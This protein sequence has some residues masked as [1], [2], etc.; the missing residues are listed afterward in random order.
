[1]LWIACTKPIA[2]EDLDEKQVEELLYL[3][4]VKD[5]LDRAGMKK[6]QK[7]QKLHALYVST[8]AGLMTGRDGG[9]KKYVNMSCRDNNRQDASLH[10]IRGLIFRNYLTRSAH[11]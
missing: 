8:T 2:T 10:P 6:R 7:Q 3:L 1:M 11:A 5:G 4:E 9:A